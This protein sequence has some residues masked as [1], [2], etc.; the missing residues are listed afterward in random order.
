MLSRRGY[1]TSLQAGLVG[2][3]RLAKPGQQAIPK[4]TPWR[5]QTRHQVAKQHVQDGRSLPIEGPCS[6]DPVLYGRTKHTLR[7]ADYGC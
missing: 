4:L 2:V 1:R 3:L 6:A 5:Y 7:L